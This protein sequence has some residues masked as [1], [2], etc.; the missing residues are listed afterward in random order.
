MCTKCL[1]FTS[2]LLMSVRVCAFSVQHFSLSFSLFPFIFFLTWIV[3]SIYMVYSL[4]SL[5]AKQRVYCFFLSVQFGISVLLNLYVCMIRLWWR[6]DKLMQ[7]K[8][9]SSCHIEI[10]LI[11]N[12]RFFVSLFVSFFR[13]FVVVVVVICVA[14]QLLFL[15]AIEFFDYNGVTFF[16]SRCG[17]LRLLSILSTLLLL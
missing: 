13:F 11:Q 9:F 6:C 16:F 8:W 1:V 2:N 14:H 15:S 10:S 7:T 5:N 4:N 3:C 17:I 12:G